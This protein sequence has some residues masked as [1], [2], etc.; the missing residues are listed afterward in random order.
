MV[1]S[2]CA[3]S[4]GGLGR[5]EGGQ[6][7]GAVDGNGDDATD[8]YQ[9]ALELRIF[10]R[11]TAS[12]REGLANLEDAYAR[13]DDGEVWLFGMH[14]SPYAYSRGDL[15]PV[16]RRKLLLHRAEI[17]E[18]T[19]STEQKGTYP[20]IR[21][22]GQCVAAVAATTQ[23]IAEE[24]VRLIEVEYEPLEPVTDI[25]A[26][27]GDGSARAMLWL[28]D[29]KGRRVGTPADKIAYVEIDEDGSSKRVGFGR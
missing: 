9:T 21:Y 7:P 22:A 1:C 10:N 19:R 13:I 20:R 4:C 5:D 18:M 26:A 17:E 3:S 23:A 16:R 2:L 28:T 24:A 11:W 15:D 6:V 25:E 8:H 14:V 29:V 27:M 12:L